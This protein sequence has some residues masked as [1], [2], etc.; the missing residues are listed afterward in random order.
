MDEDVEAEELGRG[1][2]ARMMNWRLDVY[3]TGNPDRKQSI[4]QETESIAPE[5]SVSEQNGLNRSGSIRRSGSLLGRKMKKG[6]RLSKTI[7]KG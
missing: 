5:T 7:F 4:V 6:V 2:K 3:L 1:E